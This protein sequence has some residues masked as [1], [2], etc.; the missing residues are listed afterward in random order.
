M[1]SLEFET[2]SDQ[3]F[4]R[5]SADF[6]ELI[7]Q[8]PHKIPSVFSFFKSDHQPS[9]PVTTANLV[10]PESQVLNGPTSVNMM[11]LLHSTLKYGSSACYNGWS[12]NRY[13]AEGQW[14]ASCEIGNNDDNYGNTKYLPTTSDPDVVIGNLATLLTSGRISAENRAVIKTA[15]FDTLEAGK[16]EFEAMV[17]AQQLIVMTPEF[18]SNGLPK[19]TGKP[20]LPPSKPEPKDEPYKA[21][22]FL[23]LSGGMDSYNVLVPESCTG[24]NVDGQSVYDQYIE[25]RGVMALNKTEG[26]M[27]LTIDPRN[28]QQ[29]CERFAIH[30]ELEYMKT[31]YDDGDLTFFAN[32]GVINEGGMNPGNYYT[33]TRTRLFD[34]AGMQE[35][36]KK[37][38]PYNSNIGSGVLGRAK[39]VLAMKG[40]VVNA[41]AINDA[42]VTLIGSPGAS[43]PMSVV[44]QGGPKTFG[45]R[46]GA[47]KYFE[48]EE[49]ARA[50]NAETDAFSNIFGETWSEQ[51]VGGIQEG[52]DLEEYLKTTSLEVEVNDVPSSERYIWQRF[53]IINKLMQTQKE[54]HADRDVYY[55]EYGSFDHH[56]S[57]KAN[58]KTKLYDVNTNLKRF[59]EQLKADGLWDSVTV[60]VAS[61]FART[62]T[63]NSNNGSDHAWGGHYWIMG[64]DVNGGRVLGKYP[65]DITVGSPLNAGANPRVRTIPTTSWDSIWNGVIEWFGVDEEDMDYCLPN[66]HNT[67][68]PVEGEGESPLFTASDLYDSAALSVDTKRR[69]R[70]KNSMERATQS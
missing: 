54:R 23:M 25:M 56:D 3:P 42:S 19:T 16:G 9:G 51:F 17:N 49:Y 45:R 11:N 40:H 21:V 14:H 20:R 60:F 22:V 43:V 27:D 34:H 13:D 6:Q 65:H 39:D 30:P 37:V 10:S 69:L 62:I 38:D 8:E 46:P 61:D 31:L 68:M 18:H 2:D 48:I 41:M 57:M 1:R 32:T 64:G 66:R 29:P 59:V 12:W 70:G 7:G 33:K 55:V 63:P 53:N 26:E 5:F 44:S 28:P 15:Y 50:L 35:E 4:F 52:F 47:E 36:A 67:V 24:T 58:L